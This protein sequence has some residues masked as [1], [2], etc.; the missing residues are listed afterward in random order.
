MSNHLSGPDFSP[1]A[2]DA[3]LDITDLYAFTSPER[4]GHTVLAVNVNPMVPEM[5]AMEFH[6]DALYQI[7]VDSDG[8]AATDVAFN[9]TFVQ[10]GGGQ[11]A[12]VRRAEGSAATA[13][14]N[15][16]DVIIDNA[17]VSFG[18]DARVI[19]QDGY[20]FFAG[21]RSDPFFADID[22]LLNNFAWTGN[23]ALADKNVLAIILEAPDDLFSATPQIGV[24]SRVAVRRDGVFVTGDRAGKPAMVNFFAADIK[25]TYNAC[26]PSADVGQHADLFI[27]VLQEAGGYSHEDATRLTAGLLPD[28]LVLDRSATCREPNGRR[29][30]DDS[31]GNRIASMFN[32][33]VPA[34]G[35]A[36]HS[37]LTAKFPYMGTP[38][39]APVAA[40]AP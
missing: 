8:D 22:G 26:E 21:L 11:R 18:D 16:G 20:R 27:H 5:A 28:Q 7:N 9:V 33:R 23:D 24:W 34:P 36:A 29:L 19:E 37:D 3:R 17:T 12:T 31:V 4:E 25:T 30:E 1:P 14:D 2:G 15:V 10:D 13:L 32:G 35:I 6:P 40:T 39:P 38:H